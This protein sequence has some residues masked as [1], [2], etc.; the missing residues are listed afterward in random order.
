MKAESNDA[1]NLC[2]E[3]DKLT[4]FVDVGNEWWSDKILFCALSWEEFVSI[5]CVGKYNTEELIHLT[6]LGKALVIVCLIE[7]NAAGNALGSFIFCGG[8]TSNICVA[9]SPKQAANSLITLYIFP[10]LPSRAFSKK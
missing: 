1:I 9:A 4:W 3:I 5:V 7:K 8:S 2:F 6:V 10:S